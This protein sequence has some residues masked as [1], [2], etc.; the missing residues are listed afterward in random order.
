MQV[1]SLL[2][3]AAI[4]TV[5]VPPAARAGESGRIE[6][7]PTIEVAGGGGTRG[8][9]RQNESRYE[10]VDDPSV[11][12]SEDGTVSLVWV[13]QAEKDVFYRR[14]AADGS[15]QLAAPVNVSRS[16][17]TFSWL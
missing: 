4:S 8:P 1:W 6:W 17:A 12:I 5:L 16:A 9:W 14:F 3:V 10:Y 15:E 13:D 7:Q 11:A 2:L